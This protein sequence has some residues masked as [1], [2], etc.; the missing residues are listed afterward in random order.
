VPRA[1]DGRR[2]PLSDDLGRAFLYARYDASLTTG[3]LGALGC[4]DLD[5]SAL[6]A[7]D[8]IDSIAE[9]EQ[10]GR[11]VAEHQLDVTDFGPLLED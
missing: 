11:A 4:G 3:G 9:L 6:C 5:P 7:L 1:P 2:L 8:S 10:V